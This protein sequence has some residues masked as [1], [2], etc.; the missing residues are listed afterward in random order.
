[1]PT[2][3]RSTSEPALVL[4]RAAA[5]E[6]TFE[7]T[8]HHLL[9]SAVATIDTADFAGMTLIAED[10]TPT[11][12]FFTDDLSPHLD[13]AQYDAGRGPCVDA[14]RE[15]R[16]VIVDTLDD[17]A[18]HFPEFERAA[19]RVGVES[20]LGVPLRAGGRVIG[21]LNLYAFAPTSF[22]DHDAAQVSAI[23]QA[24]GT[25]IAN[26]AAYWEAFEL[27]QQL[28]EAMVNRA[29]IEQAKG[30]LMATTGTDADEA[31]EL[32]RA[33][34]QAENRKLR[35]IAKELVERQRIGRPTR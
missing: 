4:A 19:R 13:H 35:D 34:S 29:V 3:A 14:W 11:T 9:E 26:A 22:D 32:L 7:E 1:M 5:A 17:A 31:F 20:T 6:S 25:A 15:G 21:A 12:P 8:M 10:G 16:P 28:S 30:V 2:G 18:P 23:A 24:I 27:S 33:Q